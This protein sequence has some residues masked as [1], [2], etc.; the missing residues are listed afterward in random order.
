M[1]E[2]IELMVHESSI[3]LAHAVGMSEEIRPRICEIVARAVGNVVRNLDL[4][5]L[6]AID[7]VGAEIA[8]N[9]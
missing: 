1:F 5:H 6:I 7:R 3:E 2:E 4:F 9:R 8:R